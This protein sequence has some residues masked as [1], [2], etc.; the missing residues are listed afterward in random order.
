MRAA[1]PRRRWSMPSSRKLTSPGGSKGEPRVGA[2]RSSQATREVR[3]RGNAIPSSARSTA[4]RSGSQH[5]AA[6]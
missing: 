4:V 2:H 5:W 1:P 6:R 3:R